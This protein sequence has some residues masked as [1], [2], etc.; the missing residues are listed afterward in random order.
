MAT[1]TT[2]N[3]CR[4]T[5]AGFGTCETS[6]SSIEQMNSL[7]LHEFHAGLGACFTDVNAMEA[8]DHYGDPLAEHAVLRGAAAV[9]DLSFRSRLCLLGADRQKFLNGQV[10]NNVKDLKVGEG[11]YAAL[12][13][14]KAK[15]QSDLNIYILAD[16]ILLDFEPGYSAAVAQ[17]LEKYVI[18]DDV[19]VTDVAPHYGLLSVQGPKAAEALTALEFAMPGPEPAPDPSR[20]GNLRAPGAAPLP[21]AEGVG[22]GFARAT[23]QPPAK[24]MSFVRLKEATLGEIYLMNAPRVG[25]SGFDLFV[26]VDALGAVADKLIAAAKSVGGRACG[27]KALESAR[28]E[29][30]IPRFGVDMDETNLAPEAGLEMRAISYTKGCYIGQEVIA[31]IRTYGQ[32]AKSLRGLRLADSINTLPHKGDKLYWGGKEVGQI[33]SAATSP[34]LA[35]NIAL[36][37]VRREHNQ[38][39]A[40]L[41]LRTSEGESLARIIELPP[42]V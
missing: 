21:S 25:T 23:V 40:E 42:R 14:A 41:T 32:V 16:E 4:N 9:L 7:A 20:E 12:V 17:R 35:A 13:N 18:A 33:T 19:Q 38:I 3:S 8:V 10:T 26:P 34:T 24:S 11:C 22:A 31:R 30:G 5:G 39:G 29:A 2:T 28:I 1:I 37:Y 27:W 36:A 15:M 6:V